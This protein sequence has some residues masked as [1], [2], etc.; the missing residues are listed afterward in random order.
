MRQIGTLANEQQVQR[1][2]DYLLTL[3]IRIQVEEAEGGIA[4]WAIEEDRVSQAREEFNR[5][6]QNPEDERYQAAEREA[7]R[8]REQLLRQ[9]RDRQRNVI[10]IKG[11]WSI[12]RRKPVTM[13]LIAA[14]CLVW[15]ATGF[16]EDGRDPVLQNLLIASYDIHGVYHLVFRPGSEVL[17][18]EIWR[19]ITPIF[20]HFGPMHLLM[21]MM[22]MHNLGTVLEI[23]RGSWRLAAMV[24]VIALISNLAQYVFS[25]PSFGGMSGVAFGLFGYAWMKSEFDREAGMFIPR[26]SVTMMLGWLVLCMTGWIGPIANYAHFAGLIAGVVMG[27]A[28]I[29]RRQVFGR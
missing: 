23:R 7:W 15:F 20:V 26:S 1:I 6:L 18:G 3:G 13:L 9:E 2:A 11:Q 25:G 28:P 5:F 27:Y 8:L 21:N 4:I 10:D 29:A 14:S 12:S 24:F 19:L 16:G 22:A 17:S